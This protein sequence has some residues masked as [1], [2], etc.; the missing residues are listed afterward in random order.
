MGFS[1]HVAQTCKL[2]SFNVSWA[3]EDFEASNLG[4]VQQVGEEVTRAALTNNVATTPS[5]SQIV[6]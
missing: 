3:E 2:F 6:F 5:A 4:F 1:N